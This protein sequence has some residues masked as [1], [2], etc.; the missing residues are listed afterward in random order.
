M[1][2]ESINVHVK[3]GRGKVRVIKVKACSAIDALRA[4]IGGKLDR[5]RRKPA[6]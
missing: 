2:R 3:D 6:K 1:K 4:S 5:E